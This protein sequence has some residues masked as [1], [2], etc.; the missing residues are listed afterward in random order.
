MKNLFNF[1]KKFRNFLLF[2]FLQV[3]I[4][5]IYFNSKNYHKSTFINTSSAVSGWM[6]EKRYNISK[7]F[8]LEKSIDSL[9]KSNAQLL[10][11]QTKSFYQLQ[12]KIYYIND[13]IY[14]QQYEYVPATVINSTTNKRNNYVTINKGSNLG[15]EKGMGVISDHGIVGF[16]VDVSTHYAIIKTILSDKVNVGAKIKEQEEVRGQIKWDG[17]DSEVCQLHGITS[18][19]IVSG[20]ETIL[21]KGS[22]G[23]YPEGIIIG[24]IKNDFENDGSLTLKLNIELGVDFSQLYTVYLVKNILK[25]EQKTIEENYFN[26]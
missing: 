3:F 9:A 22:N 20:G 1:L 25:E 17:S 7:H 5:G 23:V 13:S 2:F 11:H 18:D 4:L 24:K 16:V 19:I 10:A 26:E 6:L 15:V 12:D 21:T 8:T 14:E